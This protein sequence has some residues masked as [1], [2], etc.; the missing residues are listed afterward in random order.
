MANL[1]INTKDAFETWGVRM[2]EG[3]LNTLLTPPGLKDFTEN[4]S[5]QMDGKEII[6]NTPKIDSRD[7]TLT[8]TIEGDNED[9]Y[10]VKY[11]SFVEELRKGE[12][13]LN[14]PSISAVAI[15][16][17]KLTYKSAQSY[18]ISGNRT[19]SKISVKFNQANPDDLE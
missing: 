6:Y 17:Y 7:L 8:F 11:I 3:F 16:N 18:A 13:V 19:F 5:K 14:I 1:L 2:G 4:Q 9:D 10:W 15:Y 12:I